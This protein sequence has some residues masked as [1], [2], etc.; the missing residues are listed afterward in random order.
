MFFSIVGF[1]QRPELD[2]GNTKGR[3][4]RECVGGRR[5]EKVELLGKRGGKR[6]RRQECMEKGF[7]AGGWV[8]GGGI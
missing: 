8:A 5:G 3:K 2:F 1:C 4:G 7:L 6:S